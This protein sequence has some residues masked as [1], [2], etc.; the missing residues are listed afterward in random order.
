MDEQKT[1]N[2][3]P[4]CEEVD[5]K[6]NDCFEGVKHHISFEPQYKR[7]SRYSHRGTHIYETNGKAVLDVENFQYLINYCPYCGR[8][9]GG[10]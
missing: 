1:K 10:E 8:K 5:D 4:Y 6:W 9:L 2:V 3:C 7:D